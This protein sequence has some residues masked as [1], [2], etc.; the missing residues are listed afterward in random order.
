MKTVDVVDDY[1]PNKFYVV[2]MANRAGVRLFCTKLEYTHFPPRTAANKDFEL[3]IMKWQGLEFFVVRVPPSARPWCNKIAADLGMRL[4]DGV[5]T[6]FDY[7]GSYSFPLQGDNIWT[8]EG[9]FEG[10]EEAEIEKISL[11]MNPLWRKI[12]AVTRR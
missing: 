7:K 10:D 9:E 12:F 3:A 6:M 4:A 11:R 1:D 5:P 8:L 2:C